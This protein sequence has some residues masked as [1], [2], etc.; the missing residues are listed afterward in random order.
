MKKKRIVL[1]GAG[2]IGTKFLIQNWNNITID[3]FFDNVREGKLLDYPIRK[4]DYYEDV[5]IIV[6]SKAYL[7]IKEQ[8]NQTGY[9][10]FDD[11][12]PSE[13]YGKKMAIAYGNCHMDSVKQYLKKNKQFSSDYG[14]YPFPQIQNMQPDF[15]YENIIKKCALF[16]HQSIREDNIFGERYSSKC[17]LSYIN[18]KCKVVA[19]PNLYGMPKYLF[20]QLTTKYK[21][22]H[23]FDVNPFFIDSNIVIWLKDGK[24]ED[25]IIKL[26]M[27]GGIYKKEE[28]INMWNAFCEKL[29]EREKEWDIKI[30]NYIL[31]NYKNE[32]I[33][34][35]INHINSKTSGEIAACTLKFL[36]YESERE[37]IE[38]PF[39]D[40][41]EAF[42]Y[43]DVKKALGLQ[44]EERFIRR[45]SKFCCLNNCEMDL[46]EYYKQLCRYTIYCL[47]TDE[48]I[49]CEFSD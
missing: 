7:E 39:M 1:F 44:Y 36:G 47:Q 11:F 41:L 31:T 16:I 20:P 38:L 3:C 34:C 5:F 43:P 23:K 6:T 37:K 30:S 26:I 9:K 49:E 24:S 27:E 17:L 46:E 13:I 14:F 40:D 19:I 10:E 12:I 8:L 4:P 48:F 15:K 21:L 45:Y 25:E 18:S 32:K 35:D 2:V 28:I 22:R 29:C 33:F 42:I